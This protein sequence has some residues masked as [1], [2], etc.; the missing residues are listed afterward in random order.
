MSTLRLKQKYTKL[1]EDNRAYIFLDE[2][3]EVGEVTVS[4]PNT[5]EVWIQIFDLANASVT[6]GTTVAN[7]SYPCTPGDGVNS[8]TSIVLGITGHTPFVTG[9]SYAITTDRTGNTAPTLDVVI[10]G[11][12]R[13]G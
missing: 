13:K 4:N 10:N 1:A 11:T 6:V 8:E 5:S 2:P 9:F 7:L 3:C 12:Y